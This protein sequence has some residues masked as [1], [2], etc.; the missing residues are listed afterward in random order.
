LDDEQLVLG[1]DLPT[2]RA[3]ALLVRHSVSRSA[4]RCRRFSGGGAR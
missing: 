4:D 1:G 2:A 3:L